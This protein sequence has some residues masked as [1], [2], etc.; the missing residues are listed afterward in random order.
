MSQSASPSLDALLALCGSY[1]PEADLALI[2]QAYDAAAQAHAGIFRRSGEPYIEHPLA[3]ARILA[4]LAVDAHGIAAALLHDTV[5]DTPLKIEALRE[6]FGPQ[7]AAIVDGVTKFDAV[8][9]PKPGRQVDQ[10]GPAADGHAQPADEHKAGAAAATQQPLSAEAHREQKA[11]AHAETVHKLFL[12]MLEDPRVV[13]LKLADRLHNMRTMEVM[14]ARQRTVKS[15]EVVD[16][17]APLA[18]RIGLY[19]FKGELED[20]AFAYLHPQEFERTMQALRTQEQRRGAWA[21]RMCELMRHELGESSITAAVN[22]RMKRPYRAWVEAHEAG[23][24]I[25]GLNDLITFR[26]LVESV[27]EC[28]RA[29][30]EIHRL[31]MPH[32]RIRD[33]IAN[34]KN[35]GYQSLHT[36]VFALDGHLAPIHIRS[37]R[38]HRASQHGVATYWL[39]RAAAGTPIERGESLVKHMPSWVTQLATWESDLKLNAVD[40]LS[41]VRAEVLEEDS[42]FVFT[43]RGGVHELPAGATVLD[44]AYQIHTRVGDQAVGAQIQTSNRDGTIVAREVAIDYVLQTGDVVFVRTDLRS[45]P[46]PEWRSIAAT[47]YAREKIARALRLLRREPGVGSELGTDS[48]HAEPGADAEPES[49]PLRHPSGKVA[50]VRLAR[51]CDPCPPDEIVGVACDGRG[52][53][54]HRR[55]CRQLRRIMERR[56]VRAGA[57]GTGKDADQDV[58]QDADLERGKVNRPVERTDERAEASRGGSAEVDQANQPVRQGADDDVDRAAQPDGVESAAGGKQ[59]QGGAAAL[60]TQ[61]LVTNWDTLGP[62]LYRLHLVLRGQDHPGL[63]YEVTNCIAGLGLNVVYT[64]ALTNQDRGKALISLTVAVPA[65]VRRETVMRRLRAVP[66]VTEVELDVRKGCNGA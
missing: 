35:N 14:S 10:E 6:Q 1:M 3:V 22:W 38:M 39:E 53:T 64:S 34:I 32:E 61:P 30:G 51:C 33:Y 15:Q 27:G 18:G 24:R 50:N 40:F 45:H 60:L 11:R 36:A 41:A 29:L 16:I 46:R 56:A 31:W 4:E 7:I 55:C 42:V 12:A 66:G 5:E 58:G 9:T 48:S 17:Y 63:M 62:V 25:S 13:L 54:I 26:V 44:Y 28:Y 8:E 37:H 23:V 2:R 49:L 65:D 20:L 19:A 57:G 59:T 43:P 47:R 21:E 52:V